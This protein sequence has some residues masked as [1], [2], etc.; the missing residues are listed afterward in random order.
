MKKGHHA[1][2]ERLDGDRD[3]MACEAS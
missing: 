1:Y 3:G 2:S